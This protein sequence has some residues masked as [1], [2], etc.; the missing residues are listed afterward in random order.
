MIEAQGLSVSYGDVQ[1]LSEVS[2][3][4]PNQ[5]VTA[6]IGMNGAGKSTLFKSFLG[7]VRPT[8]GT[9][10]VSGTSP[11]RARKSGLVAYMPQSEAVDWDFP[12]NVAD[13][14]MMGRFGQQNFMRRVRRTDREAVSEALTRVDLAGYDKRQIGE[15]S[16]G[17]RKRVFLARAIAQEAKILLLD[18]PFSGVDQFSAATITSVIRDIAQAGAAVLVSTH[19]LETLPQLADDAVLLM[20]RVQFYGSVEEATLPENLALC[21]SAGN[22]THPPQADEVSQPQSAH[23]RFQSGAHQ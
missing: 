1:A 7:L 14:V 4:L 9:V 6:L 16:G 10:S 23:E 15:L 3:K 22:N 8:S 13:V 19:D 5:R 18:E 21:F 2:L 20:Q 12:V 11:A 17:Q